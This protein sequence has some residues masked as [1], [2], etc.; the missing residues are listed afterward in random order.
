LDLVR[1]VS[2][3]RSADDAIRAELADHVREKVLAYL[4][5]RRP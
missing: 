4:T 5:G 3:S 1:R 2:V